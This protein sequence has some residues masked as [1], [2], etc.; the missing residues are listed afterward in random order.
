MTRTPA[1]ARPGPRAGR[2]A[3]RRRRARSRRGRR[4]G[5]RGRARGDRPPAHGARRGSFD[6]RHFDRDFA[7][8]QPTAH[9]GH[10][11]P[12]RRRPGRRRAARS[13]PRATPAGRSPRTGGP[14]KAED[15]PLDP[16]P[17]ER[18]A[19]DARRD[20]PP[21]AG[22]DRRS[23]GARASCC[24]T[25]ASTAR[26]RRSA[27]TRTASRS[28]LIRKRKFPVVGDG[29]GV[30]SF[31]HIEDAADGH[32]GRGRARRAA[33][34]YNVVDDEPAPV[35]RV[36][37]GAGAARSAPSRRGTCPRWLGRLAGRRGRRR[38]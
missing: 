27:S 17:P 13:S 19:R 30:W 4:R 1:K 11:P 15:D 23:T 12:A 28:T 7:R 16:D 26:A 32:R 33:G 35:A 10:R 20:P 6:L 18:H 34:I 38:S 8:D 25:A 37:A 29:G 24:A 31:I 22:R 3:G 5:G 36:A 2:A 9:R 14:V 21:R